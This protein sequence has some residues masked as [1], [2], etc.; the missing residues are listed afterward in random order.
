MQAGKTLL[1]DENKEA[2]KLVKYDVG[3]GEIQKKI[4]FHFSDK[5]F[6]LDPEKHSRT[7]VAHL[8]RD[9][10]GYIH[11]GKNPRGISPREAAR[12]QSFPDWYK[13]EGH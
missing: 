4:V 2:F 12:I 11:Y 3:V 7:I 10:N 8:N 1:S 13:F 9:N 6:K 5:Y